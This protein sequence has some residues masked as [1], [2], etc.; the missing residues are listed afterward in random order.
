MVELLLECDVEGVVYGFVY[1]WLIDLCVSIVKD[2][3]GRE[4]F[5][6]LSFV[7]LIVVVFYI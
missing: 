6:V 1:F 7:G 2:V 3:R 4:F 5:E